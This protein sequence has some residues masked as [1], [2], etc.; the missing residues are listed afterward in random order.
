MF[1]RRSRR[2]QGPVPEQTRGENEVSNPLSVEGGEYV[3]E[4]SGGVTDTAVAIRKRFEDYKNLYFNLEDEYIIIRDILFK[5]DMSLKGEDETMHS[6]KILTIHKL[7]T[8]IK[9]YLSDPRLIVT[10]TPLP[11]IGKN[12]SD[13]RS[14]LLKVFNERI[15][16]LNLT[17]TI[18]TSQENNKTLEDIR[19]LATE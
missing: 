11:L 2:E 3:A 12:I 4:E 5:T 15:E 13:L 8:M 14:D 10:T 7:Y 6:D 16:L 18:K 17:N 19:Q 9:E 1:S